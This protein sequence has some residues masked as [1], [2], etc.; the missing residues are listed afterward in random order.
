[1]RRRVSY[2]YEHSP[3]RCPA[4]R[5]NFMSVVVQAKRAFD[6]AQ[7]PPVEGDRQQK[8]EAFHALRQ[9]P[10]QVLRPDLAYSSD[11]DRS[12]HMQRLSNIRKHARSH[13]DR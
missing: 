13:S 7:S 9:Q 6:A 3:I 1:M 11:V 8:R 5:L 10:Q 12:A 2:P 4:H